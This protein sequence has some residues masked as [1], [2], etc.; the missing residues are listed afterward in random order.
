MRL[1]YIFMLIALNSEICLYNDAATGEKMHC[2]L[3]FC[4]QIYM[5]SVRMLSAFQDLSFLYSPCKMYSQVV[6]F[7]LYAYFILV[8][9]LIVLSIQLF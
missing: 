8:S 1:N 7:T 6:I 5:Y 9:V 4:K 2:I 3:N